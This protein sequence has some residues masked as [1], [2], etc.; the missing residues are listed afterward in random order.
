M[1]GTTSRTIQAVVRVKDET[2]A[3]LAGISA[4]LRAI[5]GME[6]LQRIRSAA[7]N[8]QRSVSS[9]VGT[10]TRLGI[11]A[12]ALGVGAGVGLAAMIRGTADT[13]GELDDLS[14]R[15]GI[16][17]QKLQAF[18]F[19]AVMS[20]Q[21]G[22]TFTAAMVRLNRGMSQAAAGGNRELAGLFQRLGI[23]LR[24]S[25]GRV[26]TAADALPQLA[27]AFMRNEN[28]ALRTRMA[29]VA[30]GRSGE[31]LLPMFTDGAE[32]L[33]KLTAMFRQYGYEFSDDE[34][35]RGASFGDTMDSLMV[36][37]RGT[38]DAIGSQLIPIVE[39]LLQGLRDWIRAN[40]E[41]VT[42]QVG[43]WARGVADWI[44]QIDFDQVRESLRQFLGIAQRVFE[45]IGGWR[46]TIIAVAAVITGPLLAAL[47]TLTAA[48]VLNPIGAAVTAIAAAAALI[49]LHWSDIVDFFQGIWDAI[50]TAV[51]RFANSEQVQWL[52]GAFATLGSGLVAAWAGISG[53]FE[54]LWD[55]VGVAVGRFMGSEQAHWLANAFATLGRGLMAA[56]AGIAGF[57]A[58]L[59]DQV[60]AAV[61]RFMGSEQVQWLGSVFGSLASVVMTAWQP[62]EGFFRSLWSGISSAFTAGWAVIGP[63]VTMVLRGARALGAVL[64]G[65]SGE[66][67]TPEAQAQRAQN[68]AGRGAAGGFYGGPALDPDTGRPAFEPLY[69]QQSAVPP[70]A[71]APQGEVRVRMTFD[72]VPPGARVDAESTGSGVRQPELDVGYAMLGAR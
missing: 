55:G 11:A 22:E 20:G 64:A 14:K 6:G 37:I 63:I 65:G 44:G 17:T 39:P 49:Y 45:T 1:S 31:A 57:F 3:A 30:F 62:L 67:Y 46:G 51:S 12:G 47:A 42:T 2:A 54:R 43:E 58:G 10:F 19:A 23:S 56:W 34:I 60:S 59:W 48:L 35:A 33:A 68:F 40:R 15:L 13:A 8:V 25:N 70:A 5:A 52:A 32:G 69:R 24:D 29:M 72:G 4:R 26:R 61:G 9:L 50:G 53:F 7:M 41:L 36:S 71:A 66:A 18:R 21:S 28:A 38:A 27:Q 16:S